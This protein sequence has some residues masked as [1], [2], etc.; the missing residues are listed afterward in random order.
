VALVWGEKMPVS[1]RE[2]DAS[3]VQ[4]SRGNHGRLPVTDLVVG[5]QGREQGLG[6]TQHASRFGEPGDLEGFQEL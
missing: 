2:L 4:D 1:A 5:L 3:A 6:V